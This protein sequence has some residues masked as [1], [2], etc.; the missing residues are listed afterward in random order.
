[1]LHYADLSA[2]EVNEYH[3]LQKTL[4]HYQSLNIRLKN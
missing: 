1:M 2:E 4:K 3:T